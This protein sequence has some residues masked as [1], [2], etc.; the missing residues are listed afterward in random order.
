MKIH[1]ERKPKKIKEPKQKKTKTIHVG[2]HKKSVLF[3]WVILLISIAFGIYKNMTAIDTHTIHE[4]KIV[5]QQIIDTHS[6]ENFTTNFIKDFYSWQNTKEG[7][8]K[9]TEKINYYLTS[10]LQQLNIDSVR[11]DIPTNSNVID[12]QIWEVKQLDDNNFSVVY[13]V[14]QEIKEKKEASTTSS[15]YKIVIH[16]ELDNSLIITKN[17]TIWSIPIHSEYQPKEFSKESNVNEKTKI[18]INLFLETFF[19]LYPSA[20]KEELAYYVETNSLPSINRNNLVFLDL[21]P[22]SI[23]KH[24][25]IFSTALIVTYLD[26][27][28]KLL[29]HMNYQ[30]NLQ[31]LSNWKINS[32]NEY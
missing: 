29:V 20:T 16:Q 11:S 31:K 2:T 21:Q 7:I 26:E 27:D 3:L 32:I 6:I 4:K 13:S 15:N 14:T 17:P 10:Q 24:K 28:T 19:K 22:F 9:R 1:I 23:N 25:N 8:E 30:L 18:E 12:S 5:E